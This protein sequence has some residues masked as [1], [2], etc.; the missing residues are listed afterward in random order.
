MDFLSVANLKEFFDD[1]DH[2][3]LVAELQATQ[4]YLLTL[5]NQ[6]AIDAVI[7]AVKAADFS[8]FVS[9]MRVTDETGLTLNDVMD[10]NDILGEFEDDLINLVKAL[11]LMELYEMLEDNNYS[12]MDLDGVA[13]INAEHFEQYVKDEATENGW[14]AEHI[15]DC[16]NWSD[17]AHKMKMQY[18]SAGIECPNLLNADVSEF[19]YPK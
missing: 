5:V 15:A 3:A 13:F 19:Y 14:V 10:V 17:Y 1:F 11:E 4:G 7:D 6:S 12:G 18:G 9:A 2:D 8:Q 16:V